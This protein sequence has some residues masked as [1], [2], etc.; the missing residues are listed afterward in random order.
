MGN[1]CIQTTRRPSRKL[2]H[3]IERTGEEMAYQKKRLKAD[4][5]K[6]YR[7][8]SPV[9]NK[10]AI[11]S[12]SLTPYRNKYLTSNKL[13]LQHIEP[14]AEDESRP[15][16]YQLKKPIKFIRSN[17]IEKNKDETLAEGYCP[18]NQVKLLCHS[19]KLPTSTSKADIVNRVER[20]MAY[21]AQLQHPNLLNCYSYRIYKGELSILYEYPLIGSLADLSVS[22]KKLDASLVAYYAKQILY[23]LQYLHANRVKHLNIHPGNLFLTDADTIKLGPFSPLQKLNQFCYIDTEKIRYMSPEVS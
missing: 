15:E 14:E 12:Q 10:N 1:T 6:S 18:N 16:N 23:A 8:R 4:Y 20:D 7:N 19:L 3:G 22:C 13:C 9:R 5:D 11:K 17:T 21:R 2:Q